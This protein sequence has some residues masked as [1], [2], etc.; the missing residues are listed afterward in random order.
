VLSRLAA[1]IAEAMRASPHTRLLVGHGSGSF[2]HQAA[3]RYGTLRGAA[4]RDQWRGFADVWAAASRLNRLV[5]DALSQEGLPVIAFPPSASTVCKSGEIIGMS[6]EPIERAL[7]SELLPVVAGDVA[8]DRDWG[9]TI[10]STEKVFA[11]LARK[12]NPRRVLLAG[13]E[14]GV[15]ADFPT[16]TRVLPSLRGADL[17]RISLGGSG[18][19]DVTGGMAG[20]V[21]EA[22]ALAA[23]IPGL[24]VRIFSGVEPGAVRLAIL[25]GEPGT[26]IAA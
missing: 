12:L 17:S 25:G 16:A 18:A 1:E 26:L 22:L 24:E 5:V 3:A 4:G 14:P 8:F 19:T 11:F 10:V 13:I 15:Y 9:A 6:F 7:A 2:G 23:S 21:R 20:K